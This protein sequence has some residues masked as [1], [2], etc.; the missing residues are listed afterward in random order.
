MTKK[1][2]LFLFCL[3]WALSLV[4]G[5]LEDKGP[6]YFVDRYGTARSSST[7]SKRWFIGDGRRPATI[8]GPFS[9]RTFRKDKL[10]VEAVFFLPSLKVAGV[11]L[12]LGQS[13]TDEQIQ[14]ALKAYGDDWKRV[15]RGNVFADEWVAPDG[16]NAIHLASSL[17]IQSKAV[18]DAVVKELAEQDAKRKAVPMF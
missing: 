3:P 8:K 15:R 4:A 14:A 12:R 6:P 16:S 18:V 10:T 17:Y 11:T 7:E 1:V 2:G 9:I 13:W 5:P